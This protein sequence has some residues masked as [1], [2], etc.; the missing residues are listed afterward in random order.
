M[1]TTTKAGQ[2]AL[3]AK[4]VSLTE[5]AEAGTTGKVMVEL[6]QTYHEVVET[7]L[8]GAWTINGYTALGKVLDRVTLV[9]GTEDG[10]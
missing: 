1:T 8:K 7:V 3:L 4:L 9:L 2:Q 5:Q 10:T 6:D